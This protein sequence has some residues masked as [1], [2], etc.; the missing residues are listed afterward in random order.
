MC[1]RD[2]S[3]S[4]LVVKNETNLSNNWIGL[5]LALVNK[6]TG[7]A[8]PANREIAFYQGYDGGESWSEGSREDEISFVDIAPG[9]YYLAVDPDLSP[10]TRAPIR[11]AVVVKTASAAWSN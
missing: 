7:T 4:K 10:E 1:I 8:Y 3:N 2:R 5:N 9:Q 6:K 11:S